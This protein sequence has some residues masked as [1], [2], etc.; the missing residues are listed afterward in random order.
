MLVTSFALEGPSPDD[1][2]DLHSAVISAALDHHVMRGPVAMEHREDLQVWSFLQACGFQHWFKEHPVGVQRGDDP[3]DYVLTYGDREFGMELTQL[4]VESLRQNLADVR[5][6]GRLCEERLNSDTDL[7]VHLRGRNIVIQASGSKRINHAVA[8][9]AICTRLRDNL[10][11]F[12]GTVPLDE[13]RMPTSFKMPGYYGI[14]EEL[15]IRATVENATPG[16]ATVLPLAQMD[17]TRSEV[18]KAL[19]DLVVEKDKSGNE[20]L[21]ITTSAIDGAGYINPADSFLFGRIMSKTVHLTVE[22]SHINV[23]MMHDGITGQVIMLFLRPGSEHPFAS[24][25]ADHV[26]Q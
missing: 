2:N 17:I 21:L 23:I 22:P 26:A 5:R 14:V 3:P 8:V 12:N 6:I 20:I 18:E 13:A 11:A 7:Y 9:E 10:G 24:R 25:E 15:M 19:N 16:R 1:P 4:T